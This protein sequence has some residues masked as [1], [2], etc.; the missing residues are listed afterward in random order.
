[1]YSCVWK[2]KVIVIAGYTF[3]V[4]AMLIL[5]VVFSFT[6]KAEI[7]HSP[8]GSTQCIPKI[9]PAYSAVLWAPAFI[10]EI[11]FVSLA[12]RIAIK[13]ARYNRLLAK[14][15]TWEGFMYDSIVYFVIT[16][17]AFIGNAVSWTI[18]PPEWHR[19]PLGFCVV[20]TCVIGNRLVLNLRRVYY[21]PSNHSEDEGIPMEIL[22]PLRTQRRRPR[23]NY[24]NVA[25]QAPYVRS[26]KLVG[27]LETRAATP[28]SLTI[29]QS[30]REGD[31]PDAMHD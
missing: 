16:M 24:K 22:S 7:Y 28:V 27:S 6:S 21:G 30:V 26:T 14:D 29:E 5:L 20:S 11:I 4:L 31:P 25:L 2:V 17:A 1:M 3:E 12:V 23:G 19:L 13:H 8:S 18:L 10:F 15:R 9:V